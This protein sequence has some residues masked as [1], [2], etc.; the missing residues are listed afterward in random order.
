LRFVKVIYSKKG[1]YFLLKEN[2]ETYQILRAIVF[3]TETVWFKDEGQLTKTICEAG[4]L[5]TLKQIF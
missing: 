2:R 1:V 3:Q 5:L 4:Y